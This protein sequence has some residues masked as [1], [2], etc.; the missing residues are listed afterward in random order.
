MNILKGQDKDRPSNEDI[1]NPANPVLQEDP[2]KDCISVMP[3]C[4]KNVNQQPEKLVGDQQHQTPSVE[5][6]RSFPPQR[7]GREKCAPARCK[8]FPCLRHTPWG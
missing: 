3:H 2:S 7:W 1:K 6:E 4:E 8:Q 5:S